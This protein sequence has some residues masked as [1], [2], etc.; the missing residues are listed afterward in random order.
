MLFVHRYSSQQPWIDVSCKLPTTTNYKLQSCAISRHILYCS[1]LCT[2]SNGQ[3]KLK[4]YKLELDS[5]MQNSKAQD[6]EFIYL[7]PASVTQC[8]LFMNNSGK[9]MI[10]KVVTNDKGSN[11]LEVCPLNAT[12][13]KLFEKDWM[14]DAKV[15]AVLSLQS[16]FCKNEV[17]IVYYDA[18]NS[19]KYLEVISL[20][21]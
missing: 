5:D 17:G 12:D 19:Q 15:V 18:Y 9:A 8:H 6:L 16:T 20:A 7:C 14:A 10:V 4:V 21:Q 1:L 11:T 2:E 13:D 3:Q